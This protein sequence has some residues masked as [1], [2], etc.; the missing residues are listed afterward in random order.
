[1][2]DLEEGMVV[3]KTFFLVVTSSKSEFISD[4]KVRLRRLSERLDEI[5]RMFD[6]PN[7]KVKRTPHKRAPL[8]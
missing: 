2:S 8:T 1:M 6:S 7:K 5:N 3:K 4:N